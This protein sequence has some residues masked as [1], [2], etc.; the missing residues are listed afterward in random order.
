MSRDRLRKCT[1]STTSVCAS[2]APS[3]CGATAPRSSTT[4]ACQP[5]STERSVNPNNK[6]LKYLCS[7]LNNVLLLAADIL[8]SWGPVTVHS[9]VRSDP[10]DRSQAGSASR[11]SH[12]RPAVVRPRRFV[13]GFHSF[14]VVSSE[15]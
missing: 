12:V 10:S 2:T 15:W 13:A 9:D 5:S 4:S 3:R 7:Q 8:R 14:F 6:F 11:R 1:V